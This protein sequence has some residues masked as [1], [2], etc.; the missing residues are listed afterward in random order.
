VPS[1]NPIAPAAVSPKPSIAPPRE[2]V[3]SPRPAPASTGVAPADT[4]DP[5]AGLPAT[6]P[7]VDPEPTGA[8]ALAGG[9]SGEGTSSPPPSQ[10][11]PATTLREEAALLESVR[12]SLAASRAATALDALDRYDGRFPS[13]ALSE[14]AAVL[15]VE[16]LLGVGR[17]EEAR[18][19][20]EQ[21]A[22]KHPASSYVPRMRALLERK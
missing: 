22:A 19:S 3:A 1:G 7:A 10:P 16:A 4:N 9:V 14:E 17:R 21:F 5:L 12:E 11:T 13:G 6:L 18:R 2:V 20:V 8:G 15:R